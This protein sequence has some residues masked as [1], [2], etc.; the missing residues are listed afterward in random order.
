MISP[1]AGRVT[2]EYSMSRRNPATGRVEPHSGIDIANSVGTPVYA[3]FSGT[4]IGVGAGLVPGRSGDRNVLIRNP[5]GERQ[6]FGHLDTAIVVVGAKVKAGQKIGTMG[7]R[8]NVTGPHLHLETWSSKG[9]PVNPRVYFKRY[10]V[11]PGSKPNDTSPATASTQPSKAAVKHDAATRE[12]QRRQNTHADAKLLVDG[13]NG[14][15][16]QAWRAWAMQAQTALNVFSVTWPRT[17]LHVD[18]DYGPTTAADV[19]VFQGHNELHRDGILGPVMIT[20][21]RLNGSSIANRP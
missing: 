19:T 3:P 11:S 5:D 1:A 6:Y 9:K 15:V 20:W 16:T 10:G 14:P 8:G 13:I 17:A 4:V 21:M 18:G 7:A 2:S 12:Y